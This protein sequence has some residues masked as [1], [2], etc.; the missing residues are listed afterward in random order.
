MRVR[1]QKAF[2]RE[3]EWRCANPDLERE[4]NEIQQLWIVETGGPPLSAKDPEAVAAREVA[5]RSGG[6]ILLHIPADRRNS[7][8]TYFAR[9]QLKLAFGA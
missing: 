3:G 1:R 9:R 2:L 5:R 6:R 8:R 7:A 4:L